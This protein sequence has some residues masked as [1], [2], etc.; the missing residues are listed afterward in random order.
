MRQYRVSA[1]MF[2]GEYTVATA[3]VFI[4]F[5]LY[6]FIFFFFEIFDVFLQFWSEPTNNEKKSE[7]LKGQEGERAEWVKGKEKYPRRLVVS[8]RAS[9]RVVFVS[10]RQI[11]ASL[12][13][14]SK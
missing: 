5:Y 6:F 8:A 7:K 4:L 13:N 14:G 3:N 9:R 2:V 12:F 11:S 10:Q 1:S